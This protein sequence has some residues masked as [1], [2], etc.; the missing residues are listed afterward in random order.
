MDGAA[1]ASALLGTVVEVML[2][3]D[4]YLAGD[5]E[6]SALHSLHLLSPLVLPVECHQSHCLCQLLT[7]LLEP[8]QPTLRY[9]LLHL[10]P[11][12]PPTF[13]LL[14]VSQ[15][16]L[17]I[18]LFPFLLF[19]LRLLLRL[20]LGLIRQTVLIEL[21]RIFRVYR[22]FLEKD[23]Q[24]SCLCLPPNEDISKEIRVMLFRRAK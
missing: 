1:A 12:I 11:L 4:H 15:A 18:A 17:F 2:G 24:F 8:T 22:F 23:T 6:A 13:T 3:S 19:E 9:T 5:E 21:L 14:T 20:M 16:M 7:T 10:P